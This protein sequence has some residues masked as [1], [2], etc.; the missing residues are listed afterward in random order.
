MS[1]TLG[2][3]SV[4]AT[5]QAVPPRLTAPIADRRGGSA[6]AAPAIPVSTT[7]RLTQPGTGFSTSRWVAAPLHAPV[8]SPASSP[9]AGSVP[10]CPV[11]RHVA[12]LGISASVGMDGGSSRALDLPAA[13]DAYLRFLAAGLLLPASRVAQP[14]R[15]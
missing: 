12:G 6:D 13:V 14:S 4:R 15:C 1:M 9:L 2:A 3:L 10:P 5:P 8:P 7:W 11:Q